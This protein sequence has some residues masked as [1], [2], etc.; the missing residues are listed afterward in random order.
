MNG[1]GPGQ[2]ISIC[3]NFTNKTGILWIFMFNLT[4]MFTATYR[5]FENLKVPA[6]FVGF[7]W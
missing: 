1:H 4:L 3:I 2:V 7:R 6:K 5:K